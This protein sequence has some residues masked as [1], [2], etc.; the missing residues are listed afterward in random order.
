MITDP[1]IAQNDSLQM[2]RTTNLV[3]QQEMSSFKPIKRKSIED[4]EFEIKE[5]KIKTEPKLKKMAVELNE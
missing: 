4:D 1:A 2:S 3:N 5:L